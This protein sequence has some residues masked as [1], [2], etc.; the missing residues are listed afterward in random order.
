MYGIFI[1]GQYNGSRNNSQAGKDI[2]NEIKVEISF[3]IKLMI[4]NTKLFLRKDIWVILG[5]G[6]REISTL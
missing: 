4:K 2:K 3:T 5:L 6:L 1:F